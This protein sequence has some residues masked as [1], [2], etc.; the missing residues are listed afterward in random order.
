MKRLSAQDIESFRE[1]GFHVVRGAFNEDEIA[2]LVP[3]TGDRDYRA[4]RSA[5]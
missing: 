1:Q 3:I 2:R 5:V 4:L